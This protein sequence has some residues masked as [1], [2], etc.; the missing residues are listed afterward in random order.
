MIWGQQPP[1]SESVLEA[2]RIAQREREF[3]V[4]VRDTDRIS[5]EI[6]GIHTRTLWIIGMLTLLFGLVVSTYGVM[7]FYA[8]RLM[9]AIIDSD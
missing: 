2:A 5:R 9:Q 6:G 4:T 8:W 3:T 7:A 1:D